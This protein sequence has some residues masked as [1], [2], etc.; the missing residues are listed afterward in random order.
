MQVCTMLSG[1]CIIVSRTIMEDCERVTLL[2]CTGGRLRDR[3]S[4]M[5]D[6]M[7]AHNAKHGTCQAC[8]DNEVPSL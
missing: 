1:C 5:Q 2:V 6:N 4:D 7:T 8:C 3:T